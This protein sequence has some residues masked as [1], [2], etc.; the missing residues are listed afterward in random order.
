MI[1]D[2]KP[3]SRDA[4]AALLTMACWIFAFVAAE[5]AEISVGWEFDRDG[6]AEGWQIQSDL[7]ELR[8]ADGTLRTI[9]TGD[10]AR[11]SGPDLNIAAEDNGFIVIRMKVLRTRSAILRWDSDSSPLG[12]FQL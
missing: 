4:A 6:D 12:F 3:L 11:I 9:V 7:T 2:L 5:A 10:A 1:S 8:V